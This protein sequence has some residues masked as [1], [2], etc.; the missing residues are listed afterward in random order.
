MIRDT[1]TYDSFIDTA[2]SISE[3]LTG[4][5]YEPKQTTG[6]VAPRSD[7]ASEN[8]ILLSLKD[9]KEISMSFFKNLFSKGEAF[10]PTPTQEVA[11]IPP[12]VGRL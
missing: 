8:L 6:Y 1:D 9:I 5:T 12:I 10:V 7:T 2:I 11:G 3:K 4:T